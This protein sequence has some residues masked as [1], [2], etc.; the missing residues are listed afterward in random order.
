MSL[1]AL[2]TAVGCIRS[3]DKEFGGRGDFLS[4]GAYAP[5]RLDQVVYAVRGQNF[6]LTPQEEGTV[7][8][9]V[10]ARAVNLE[11]TQITL[12]LDENAATLQDT[13]SRAFKPFEPGSRAEKTSE[14]PPKDNPYGAHLWGQIQ[15]LKGLEL[16][17]WFFFE[18]PVDSVF[19]TFVWEDV[20]YVAVRYPE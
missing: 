8:A 10:R 2:G 14:T 11:S 4:I 19:A 13:E 3:S 9:A 5:V 17:G 6:V 16:P 15:L 20:E 18:V 1:V 12:S 7:I